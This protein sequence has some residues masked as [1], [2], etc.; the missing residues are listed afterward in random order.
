VYYGLF[1]H[2]LAS[3]QREAFFD[4]LDKFKS[5]G[6]TTAAHVG[7]CS[8]L[9]EVAHGRR[10]KFLQDFEMD[11]ASSVRSAC[12]ANTDPDDDGIDEAL[13]E[14]E[15][16]I[17]K[18]CIAACREL[19]AQ[20]VLNH[21]KHDYFGIPLKNA[22][23]SQNPSV[24][25]LKD[26]CERF[27]TKMG[28]EPD[29]PL[30]DCGILLELFRCRGNVIYLDRR[31]GVD[32]TTVPMGYGDD[33][34]CASDDEMPICSI[35][36]FHRPGHFDLLYPKFSFESA[37]EAAITA[38]Q[39]S[40]RNSSPTRA[41]LDEIT[42]EFVQ[43][44]AQAQLQ[45]KNVLGY[46]EILTAAN[47]PVAPASSP[48]NLP[49]DMCST[50]TDD[51]KVSMA[52]FSSPRA[53]MR[54]IMMF[55]GPPKSMESTPK[56]AVLTRKSLAV[57]T[58]SPK[59]ILRKSLDSTQS[60]QSA[61]SMRSSPRG[62]IWRPNTPTLDDDTIS[63]L[64]DKA[65][66]DSEFTMDYVFIDETTEAELSAAFFRQFTRQNSPMGCGDDIECRGGGRVMTSQ[67]VH[68]EQIAHMSSDDELVMV[69]VP[70]PVSDN[71]LQLF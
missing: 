40:I 48:Y 1:E 57:S 59:L 30:V 51:D 66:S 34:E 33:L 21:E 42:E 31:E 49:D 24:K 12:K 8:L 25:N 36:M 27:V 23:L 68:E 64:S 4:I 56:M 50:L 67:H 3:D 15:M 69:D 29:G 10:W 5:L 47:L 17:D 20:Y 7:L 58:S 6:I 16:T 26:Y 63:L 11:V 37:S 18:A 53:A 13:P 22:L 70:R 61:A 19:L 39:V 46:N 14:D 35:H 43:V 60:M 44:R 65:K 71:D 54:K 41:D 45:K 55:H 2:L 62:Y 52:S 28:V 32:I 9:E 38:S